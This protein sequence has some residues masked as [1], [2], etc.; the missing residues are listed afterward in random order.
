[1]YSAYAF[2]NFIIQ[3]YLGT[4]SIP[5]FEF[6]EKFKIM[7]L[8]FLIV[9]PIAKPILHKKINPINAPIEIQ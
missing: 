4:I 8:R 6:K 2:I 3:L 7:N 5:N 9:K 1:M